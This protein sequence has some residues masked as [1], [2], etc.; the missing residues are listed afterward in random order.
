MILTVTA[1]N[2]ILSFAFFADR[3]PN[4]APAAVLR[5]SARPERTADEYMALIC[6]LAEKKVGSCAVKH[7]IV[8]S[9]VPTLTGELCAALRALYPD[10]AY[11]TVG[12]GLRSGLSIRTEVPGELGADLVAMAVGA[13]AMHKPPFLV[14]SC[15]D[16][17]TISAVD[18]TKDV[19]VYLGCAIL[20]GPA[21]AARALN[22]EA[23]Q[24]STV[25]L[26]RP[27]HA[28]GTTTADS[29]RSGVLLGHAAA[30]EGLISSFESEI[31]KGPLPL[32]VT[33]EE[34]DRVLPYL[35]PC[36]IT[37]RELA[38]KGLLQ[39]V[40]QNAKKGKNTPKRV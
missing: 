22:Q 29:I 31:G 8:A 6:A 23:A 2:R 11:L 34:A 10:A 40:L 5:I 19:P 16:V 3:L 14:L 7:V 27:A 33:G 35:K 18:A 25:A 1:D 36:T 20:P 17:T 26:T 24:L 37:E 15:G 32:I 21:L 9:V 12:A 38:H 13:A 4:S 28:I 30:I 39:I